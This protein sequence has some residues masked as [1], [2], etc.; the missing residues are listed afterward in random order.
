MKIVSSLL[1][2]CACMPYIIHYGNAAG[3]GGVGSYGYGLGGS[4][5]LLLAIA[6]LALVSGF[7]GREDAGNRFADI[8]ISRST[9]TGQERQTYINDIRFCVKANKNKDA[10]NQLGNRCAYIEIV[11]TCVV[12]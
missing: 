10:C 5:G 9:L 6:V 12:N 2:L 4:G 7:G 8:L 3:Y 11:G 1:V